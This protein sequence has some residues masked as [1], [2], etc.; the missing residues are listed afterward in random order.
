MDENNIKP[1][2]RQ[3]YK[4]FKRNAVLTEADIKKFRSMNTWFVRRLLNLREKYF[5]DALLR[6]YLGMFDPIHFGEFELIQDLVHEE[7]MLFRME[8]MMKGNDHPPH[9]LMDTICRLT[10]RIDDLKSRLG[11]Y[12]REVN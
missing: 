9:V 4:K 3:E 6:K 10:R 5:A 7:A 8:R 11:V 2:K 12:P 1:S